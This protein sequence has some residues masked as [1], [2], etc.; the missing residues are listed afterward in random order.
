MNTAVH[1]LVL[2]AF[3]GPAPEGTEGAH[4]DGNKLNNRVDNL[5]WVT[6]KVNAQ[7]REQHGTTARGERFWSARLTS[8]KVRELRRRYAAGESAQSMAVEFGVSRH[9]AWKAATGRSW[10]HVK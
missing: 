8:D 1:R 10:Q 5:A 7:H 6:A 4:M 2:E 3:R 9:S